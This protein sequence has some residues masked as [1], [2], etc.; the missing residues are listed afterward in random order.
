MVPVG[1]A[2]RAGSKRSML[3][4]KRPEIDI[5]AP[6]RQMLRRKLEPHAIRP[7]LVTLQEGWAPLKSECI[8]ATLAAVRKSRRDGG[9]LSAQTP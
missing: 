5:A 2:S 7:Q 6:R 9:Q 1:T 3:F 8:K 4:R